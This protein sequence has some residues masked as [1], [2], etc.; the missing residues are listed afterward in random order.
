VDIPRRV[1]LT[2]GWIASLLPLSRVLAEDHVDYRYEFYKEENGRITVNTHSLLFEKKIVEALSVK[3]E[4][5]YDGISG[6]TPT[7]A[8]GSGN[9]VPT[10]KLS[11]IRRAENIAFDCKWGPQTITPQFAYSKESDYESYSISLNDAIEFN[12]KNTTLQFGA[13]HNFDE[14][15]DGSPR[16]MKRDKD[17]TEFFLGVSQLLSPKTILSAN[18]TYGSESGYLTDPY[19][20]ASFDTFGFAFHEKRPGHKDKEVFLLSLTQFISPVNASVEVSYRFYHDTFEVSSHTAALTWHQRLGKHLIIEP[21][22]RYYEQSAAY[23]YAAS[24][25]G[26]VPGPGD[27][28]SDYRLSHLSTLDYGVQAT[29]IVTDWLRLNAGYHRYEMCGLDNRTAPGMYPKANIITAGV[30]IWF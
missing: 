30:Q 11:D 29:V 4:L 22:F 3:G 5:V 18:F 10:V 6:A 12:E 27:F 21:A 1:A 19:R 13:S 15:L 24:F 16:R 2:V 20:L 17:T 7:G 28:S 25:P 14:V 8:K 9:N 26:I 23:F